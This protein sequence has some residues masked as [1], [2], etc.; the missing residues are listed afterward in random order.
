MQAISTWCRSKK[1]ISVRS[2]SNQV[3]SSP[4]AE[5]G[6]IKNI[7]S[8]CQNRREPFKDQNQL[9]KDTVIH[10]KRNSLQRVATI[11]KNETSKSLQETRKP[12]FHPHTKAE[13]HFGANN[14][15]TQMYQMYAQHKA[16]IQKSR[17]SRTVRRDRRKR[18][19]IANKSPWDHAAQ[20][21]WEQSGIIGEQI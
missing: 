16:Q 3:K 5:G 20:S 15:E 14:R 18:K 13:N 6:V 7:F 12:P 10:P 4:D 17:K 21:W 8:Q 1:N 11:Q 9:K 19:H 2:Q